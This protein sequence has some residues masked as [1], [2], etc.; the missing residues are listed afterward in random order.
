MW[1]FTKDQNGTGCVRVQK[2]G[3]NGSTVL[4]KRGKLKKEGKMSAKKSSVISR[5]IVSKK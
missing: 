3:G 4:P 2:R 1:L 5:D